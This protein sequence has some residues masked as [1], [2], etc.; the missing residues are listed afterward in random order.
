MSTVSMYRASHIL[1][2][3][4]SGFVHGAFKVGAKEEADQLARQRIMDRMVIILLAGGPKA[5]EVE[6]IALRV[7]PNL[8]NALSPRQ[9]ERQEQL[10]TALRVMTNNDWKNMVK[11]SSALALLDD[12]SEEDTGDQP[13]FVPGKG[14]ELIHGDWAWDANK[15]RSL[16][17]KGQ[18]GK[19]V[20]RGPRRIVQGKA[21]KAESK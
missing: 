12:A 19:G 3:T 11:L 6:Q 20:A 14:H 2:S 8:Q 15:A 10:A 21:A 18:H 7:V 4:V 5:L 9:G 13:L 16:H 1:A 17:N